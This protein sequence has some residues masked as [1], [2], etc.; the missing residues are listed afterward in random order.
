MQIP[1][2]SPGTPPSVTQASGLTWK[3][4]L[5]SREFWFIIGLLVLLL[6][7]GIVAFF[8]LFLPVYTDHNDTV[9]VPEVAISS[10]KNQSFIKLAEAER[11]LEDAGLNPVVLD[12]TYAP[13]LP[14]GVVVKQEPLG[15]TLV[16]TGRDV[17]LIVSRATPPLITVPKVVDGSLEQARYLLQSWKLKEGKRTYVPGQATNWVVDA[18]YKGKK[19]DLRDSSTTND[20]VPEGSKIDLVISKGLGN[21]RVEVPNLIGKTLDQAIEE[22]KNLNLAVGRVTYIDTRDNTKEGFVFEQYPVASRDSIRENFPIELKVY[23]KKSEERK[24]E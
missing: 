11:L 3:D 20:R 9:E 13:E 6:L 22:I 1:V 14:P 2:S 8:Q 16:K 24:P 5:M 15:L 19:L 12:S 17:Y 4:Y 21:S 23:G 18:Y 10:Q 7:V